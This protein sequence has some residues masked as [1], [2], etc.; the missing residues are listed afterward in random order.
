[1]TPRGRSSRG[2]AQCARRVLVGAD[3]RRLD[4]IARLL[5]AGYQWLMLRHVR[6]ARAR[7]RNLERAH[8]PAARPTTPTKDPA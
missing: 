3:A 7:A 6:R 4:R 8:A 2:R 5:G 1:M